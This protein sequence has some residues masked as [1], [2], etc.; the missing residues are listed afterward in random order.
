MDTSEPKKDKVKHVKPKALRFGPLGQHCV[1]L[2][3]DM[4]RLFAAQTDWNTPWMQ[5]V[6]PQVRTIA[7]AH[8]AETIFTRFMPLA[9]PDEG[10]GT[11][12]RYYERWRSMTAE[13]LPADLMELLKPLQAL[14]P[15]AEILD[16]IVYSPW[17]DRDLDTRL[18]ARGTD[19]VIIT[20]G[21]TDMCV[22]GTVLGAVDRGLRTI[23]ITDA[24][25]SSSDDTHDALMMLYRNRYGQ[26]IETI[27]TAA[28]ME[29]WPASV[30]SSSAC[31]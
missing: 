16:K 8:P 5:K 14:V 28:L 18:A 1:H 11:W 10:V 7:E 31:M 25:C 29:A 22:L 21:E 26:Q 20:G 3:V 30:T 9:R 13:A 17:L 19:T 2:C 24:L 6:L 23:V 12:K 4:Q 15:P 27:D